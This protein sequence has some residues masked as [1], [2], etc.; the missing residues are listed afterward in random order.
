MIHS[1]SL[2]DGP[3]RGMKGTTTPLGFGGE[4]TVGGVAIGGG[5]EG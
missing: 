5:C 3:L 2:A 4:E 1:I